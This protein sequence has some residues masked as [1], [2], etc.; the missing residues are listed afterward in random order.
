[1]V[2]TVADRIILANKGLSAN[3]KSYKSTVRIK[4]ASPLCNP[5]RPITW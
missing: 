4:A 2:Y 5:L 1:M 3:R